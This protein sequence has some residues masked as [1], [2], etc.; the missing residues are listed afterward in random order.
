MI[1]ENMSLVCDKFDLIW[2]WEQQL[3][4]GLHIPLFEN[5]G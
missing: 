5:R 2:Q 1:L 3:E 4:F